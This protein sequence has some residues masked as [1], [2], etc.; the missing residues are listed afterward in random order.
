MGSKS[1]ESGLYFTSLIVR[2]AGND[3]AAP[4][5]NPVPQNIAQ[6]FYELVYAK[7]SI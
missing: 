2:L 4:C 1:I 3:M 6:Y 5:A 7:V